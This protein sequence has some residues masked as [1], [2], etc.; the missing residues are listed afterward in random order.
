MLKPLFYLPDDVFKHVVLL[1]FDATDLM[2]IEEAIRL[3]E[4]QLKVFY[5]KIKDCILVGSTVAAVDQSFPG[6]T[7]MMC[8]CGSYDSQK[9]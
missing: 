6:C 1:F 9:A 5:E 2:N 4:I 7:C 8:L 3:D